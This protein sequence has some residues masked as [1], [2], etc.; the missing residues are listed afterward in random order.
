MLANPVT[1]NLTDR[2]VKLVNVM[3]DVV[4][5]SEFLHRY[6]IQ[7]QQIV[8]CAEIYTEEQHYMYMQML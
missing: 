5:F 8:A 7:F 3:Y 2:W 6:Q 4:Q 1:R